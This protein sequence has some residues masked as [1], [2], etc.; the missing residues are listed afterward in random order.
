MK[1]ILLASIIVAFTSLVSVQA[2]DNAACAAKTACCAS[3]ST[4]AKAGAQVKG[5]EL[6]LAKR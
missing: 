6:L 5:A 2:G 4:V 3:K 1:K